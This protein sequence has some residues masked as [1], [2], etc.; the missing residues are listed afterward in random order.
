M[1]KQPSAV[2]HSFSYA[3]SSQVDLTAMNGSIQQLQ[4]GLA[5]ELTCAG[6][7]ACIAGAITFPLH[8]AEVRLQNRGK[9]CTGHTRSTL[10]FSGML[11]TVITIARQ[12]EVARLY[13]GIGLDL[14]R[15]FSFATMPIGIY[16]SVKES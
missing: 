11:S 3:V 7:T 9:G 14:Q 16:D 1:Q 2:S 15:Q 10:K 12:E 13:G 5:A 8:V 6:S 4:L